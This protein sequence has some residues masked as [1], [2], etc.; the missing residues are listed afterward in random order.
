MN[1]RSLAH[2]MAFWE[3]LETRLQALVTDRERFA[4]V[5]QIAYWI[6]MAVVLLGGIVAVL[7]LMGVWRP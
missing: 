2:P 5:L 7:Q 6:S 3:R 4:R 1:N